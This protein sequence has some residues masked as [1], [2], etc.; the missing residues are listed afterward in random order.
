MLAMLQEYYRLEVYTAVSLYF[1]LFYFILFF[2]IGILYI[3][4]YCPGICSVVRTC[5]EL[6]ENCLPLPPEYWE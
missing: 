6:M 3:N 5:L 1:V 4:H 2:K